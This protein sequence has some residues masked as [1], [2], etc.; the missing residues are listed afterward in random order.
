MYYLKIIKSTSDSVI[1]YYDNTV[2]VVVAKN[3]KTMERPNTSR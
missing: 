2:A 1:I 3:P